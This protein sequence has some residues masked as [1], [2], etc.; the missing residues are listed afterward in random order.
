[1]YTFNGKSRVIK[2]TALLLFLLFTIL[3]L[4][5]QLTGCA[6]DN[7]PADPGDPAEEPTPTPAPTPGPYAHYV[8]QVFAYLE[9]LQDSSVSGLLPL[10][11]S[12]GAPTTT[13]SNAVAALAFIMG[14]KPER[15]RKILDIF[16]NQPDPFPGDMGGGGYCQFRDPVTGTPD[17]DAF[18]NDYRIEDNGWLLAGIK[19][20]KKNYA[21]NRYD[22]LISQ[23][24]DW[25]AFIGGLTPGS[26]LY[27]GF[28]N[29]GIL[30]TEKS[31][32]GNLILYG[33]LAGLA[34]ESTREGIK[35]WLDENVWLPQE[36]SYLPGPVVLND[37][38]AS[39]AS[40]GLLACGNGMAD[41]L[42]FAGEYNARSLDPHYI[43]VFDSLTWEKEQSHPEDQIYFTRKP[44]GS[45]STLEINYSC[46][47]DH[48]FG[49]Y[50]NRDIDLT[51][52]D[53]FSC[54]FLLRSDGS[55]TRFEIRL[56]GPEGELYGSGFNLDFTGWV[57]VEIPYPMFDDIVNPGSKPLSRI[58]Q[59][60]FV[61]INDSG[62]DIEDSYIE[63]GP[64]RYSDRNGIYPDPVTGF[65]A[66]ASEKN[67]I[68]PEATAQ[69]AA[70]YALAGQ[71]GKWF[72]YMDALSRVLKPAGKDNAW[73]LPAFITGGSNQWIPAADASAWYVIAAEGFNP[74]CD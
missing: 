24:V 32:E 51:V 37:P 53:A 2:K 30:M 68:S 18:P 27:A 61:L 69:M 4:I 15:A 57:R 63:I 42:A 55:N 34:Q 71:T 19:L 49:L 16:A 29:N 26:G 14:N 74:L 73:G 44:D 3:C 11:E 58:N 48:W 10:S 43:E 9:R 59:V 17:V 7:D 50:R 31:A 12:P 46:A 72:Y 41:I 39:L 66:F 62:A 25:F 21:D 64:V 36:G 22:N 6:V 23:L 35:E 40:L 47:K 60:E 38:A 45:G 28:S 5:V 56:Q 65:A 20:Y 1:M 70:A 52:T 33:S 67:R 54:I 8:E 13:G